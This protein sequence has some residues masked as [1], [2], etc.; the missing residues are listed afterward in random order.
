M[1]KDTKIDPSKKALEE[2]IQKKFIEERKIFLW[3]P[4]DDESAR[5]LV[6]KALYLE[7]TDNT[8]EITLYINTPGGSTTAGLV[9]YDTLKLMKSPIK[10]VVTGLAAS[11]GSILL[12]IAPKGRRFL[13]PH[14]QV[15]IHQ[16]L[17]SGRLEGVA[18]DINIYAQEMEKTRD[19][20]NKI[21]AE[22]SGQLL[23]KIRQDS[24]RDFYMN[25]QEAIQYGLADHIIDTI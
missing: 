15:L 12:C 7:W 20:L 19:I 16:P 6:E 1:P 21:L 4:I 2:L 8:K 14:A 22:S 25:A 18:V 11:M 10:L 9:I 24:D 13:L 3:G 23:S 5:T 17:I